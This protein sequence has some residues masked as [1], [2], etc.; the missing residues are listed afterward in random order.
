MMLLIGDI[1]LTIGILVAGLNF[2]KKGIGKTPIPL[3]CSSGLQ[4]CSNLFFFFD[5]NRLD[6]LIANLDLFFLFA[7]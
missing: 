2:D 1:S 3:F 7:F 5:L 4:C 6:T